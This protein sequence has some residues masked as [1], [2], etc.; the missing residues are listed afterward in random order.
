[1]CYQVR[2]W[3]RIKIWIKIRIRI[4]VM[5]YVIG[6]GACD[7]YN[8]NSNPDVLSGRKNT[9][10]VKGSMFVNGKPKVRGSG[11]G[12]VLG[13]WLFYAATPMIYNIILILILILIPTLTLTLTSGGTRFPEKY[14]LC[15]TI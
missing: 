6:V 2:V 3:V 7:N 5:L 9:G 1:M 11:L 15:G 12:L 14:G 10:V 8:L 4:R 13:S